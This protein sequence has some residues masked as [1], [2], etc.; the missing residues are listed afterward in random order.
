[1]RKLAHCP[2]DCYRTQIKKEPFPGHGG[3]PHHVGEALRIIYAKVSGRCWRTTSTSLRV[4]RMRHFGSRMIEALP[5]RK[6]TGWT[7]VLGTAGGIPARPSSPLHIHMFV[8]KAPH[9]MPRLHPHGVTQAV[10]GQTCVQPVEGPSP[11][12]APRPAQAAHLAPSPLRALRCLCTPTAYP[13]HPP[14][15][16]RAPAQESV[17]SLSVGAHAEER[18][19]SGLRRQLRGAVQSPEMTRGRGTT[20]TKTEWTEEVGR[21]EGGE[22]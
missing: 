11:L 1:M 19:L 21:E 8:T 18:I 4:C 17:G 13:W 5:E 22:R 14:H 3:A 20:K 2:S 16:P 9:M 7:T 6:G 15:S 10:T 12:P